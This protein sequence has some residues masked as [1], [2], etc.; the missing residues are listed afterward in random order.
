MVFI[1]A[2][3]NGNGKYS[4]CDSVDGVLYDDLQTAVTTADKL[5]PDYVVRS[6]A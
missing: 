2:S 4:Q 6:V 5:N 1:I 3:L